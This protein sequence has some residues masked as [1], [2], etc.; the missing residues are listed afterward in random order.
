VALLFGAVLVA[1][2]SLVVR[3]RRAAD[4]EK[5]QLKWFVYAVAL[6]VLSFFT[7]ALAFLT[8]RAS[9]I[10]TATFLLSLALIP[11]AIG[12]AITRYRLYEID[13]LINRTIVYAAVS[14][15]LLVTYIIGVAGFQFVLSPFTAGSPVAVAGST[16]AVVA[17]FQ[18]VRS[19][20]QRLVD[21]R[22]FRQRYDAERT[23][24]LFAARLRDQVELGALE[25]QLLEAVRDTVQPE[26]AS[27]WIRG[28]AV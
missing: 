1:V 24:D 12:I 25:G 22:F 2:A 10:A 4:I 21:R 15:T 11:T 3:F 14:A 28:R 23:L 18:P 20:I 6:V 26:H 5:Q 16:L 17:L 13:L 8:G 27:V 7:S 9:D 19:G